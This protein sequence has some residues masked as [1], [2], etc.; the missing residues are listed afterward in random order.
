MKIVVI[1]TGYVGLVSGACFAD[2][3]HE[4]I[5][6]D[7]NADK[8]DR[9]NKG[10]IPIYEPGLEEIVRRNTTSW[11]LSFTTDLAIALEKA[12][13]VL[14]AVGTPTDEKTGRADLQ[15]VH[16]AAKEVAEN[17]KDVAVIVTKSTVPVGTG[18]EVAKILQETRPDLHCEVASNPEFLREGSAIED[19]MHPDRIIIGAESIESKNIMQ[20]LYRKL[21]GEGVPVLFTNIATSELIKYSSN[22]FLA[23]KI[24]YA[25]EISDIC[26]NVGA[27]V[28][29]VIQGMGM[30]NRIGGKYMQ[31][32]PGYGGS[33]FPKDTLALTYIAKDAGS[34]TQIVESVIKSND[35]RKLRMADKIIAACDGSVNGKKIA[36][37]GLTFKAN[38]DDM[39]YSP[40]LSI[41]PKLLD[42]GAKIRAYDP[43]GMSEAQKIL[44]QDGIKWCSDSEDAISSTDAIVILTEW[45]AFKTLDLQQV[46]ADMSG[47]I[48][49][50]L[51]NIIDTEQASEIGFKCVTLG[52]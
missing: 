46:L 1:G 11:N 35:E 45:D 14:L 24:A 30:D 38:T 15:Y 50:D 48:L 41:I 4:V 9:L 6:V 25:N 21:I 37:L 20:R 31:P 43:V 40:S 44:T 36:I 5:C 34:T 39:R 3:G 10:E 51:R 32:G 28:S 13:C 52:K 2:M 8:I 33:C 12:E 29:M 18:K 26:E 16:A 22:A 49:I 27:D 23:M 47:N 7:K 17:L 19:F 42:A